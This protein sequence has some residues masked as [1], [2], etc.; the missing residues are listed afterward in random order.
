MLLGMLLGTMLLG[1][2][3]SVLLRGGLDMDLEGAIWISA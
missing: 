3:G 1:C 2:L